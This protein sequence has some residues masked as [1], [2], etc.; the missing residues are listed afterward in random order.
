MAFKKISMGHVA[1]ETPE[2][3]FNDLR[4]RRV[5]G[6]RAHQA[7]ILRAY[8]ERAVNEDDVALQLPTGSVKPLSDC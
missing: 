1:A 7:D 3:L 6:L 8:Y 4:T 5:A 2:A